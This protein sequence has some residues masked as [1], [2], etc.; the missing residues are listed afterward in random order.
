MLKSEIQKKNYPIPPELADVIPGYL[1][2]RE[3]DIQDL[4]VAIE[5]KD[6]IKIEK[7]AHK[8]K[9]NGASFG[10]DKLTEIGMDMMSL[11]H[12]QNSFEI[13]RLISDFETEMKQ[14]KASI[15]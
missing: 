9:G 7:V 8:L 11:S 12:Q 13:R 6:F 5:A 10:F 1:Q 2:R 4:K 3:Q 14:I 15:G